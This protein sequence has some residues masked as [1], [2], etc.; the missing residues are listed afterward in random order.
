[1]EQGERKISFYCFYKLLSTTL[2]LS[3]AIISRLR[4]TEL[5][6]ISPSSHSDHSSLPYC[7]EQ[8]VGQLNASHQAINLFPPTS[9]RI[10]TS[11]NESSSGINEDLSN[12]THLQPGKRSLSLRIIRRHFSIFYLFT[13]A[14]VRKYSE[15]STILKTVSEIF[16]GNVEFLKELLYL[17]PFYWTAEQPPSLPLQAEGQ[18]HLR[19]IA[20]KN[21]HVV[22]FCPNYSKQNERPQ[23]LF[24]F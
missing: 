3:V 17:P 22:A 7:S 15:L 6:N 20:L 2:L 8:S 21:S 14:V 5:W 24:H 23:G 16:S 4:T 9:G 19:L 12:R 11:Y 1:M 13:D 18:N 10:K